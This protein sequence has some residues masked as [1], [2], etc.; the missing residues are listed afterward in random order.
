MEK[1]FID[2]K[3]HFLE[4][5]KRK[6]WFDSNAVKHEFKDVNLLIVVEA[7]RSLEGQGLEV[8]CLV[9]NSI[10]Y[11]IEDVTQDTPFI[12]TH[13]LQKY[14]GVFSSDITPI[15]DGREKSNGWIPLTSRLKFEVWNPKK[16]EKESVL[17]DWKERL[18]CLLPHKGS[19]L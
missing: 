2:S 7:Q 15:T 10:V 9:S 12:S 11:D 14:C 5:I 6:T 13:A 16:V 1:G 3:K 8:P 17:K 19:I 18:C 4:E